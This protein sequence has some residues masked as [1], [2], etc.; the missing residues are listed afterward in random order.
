[1]ITR[2]FFASCALCA[3]AGLTVTAV[4]AQQSTPGIV[5]T[6]LQ[7]SDGPADGYVTILAR[8]DVPPGALVARHT[9]PR[10]ETAIILVGGGTLSVKG[11]PDRQVNSGDS[12]Q[13]PTGVPHALQNGNAPTSIASTYVVEK[14]KPLA[15]PAP[16]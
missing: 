4:E 15:T 13:I 11:Q 9:H 5:R 10:I 7:Q 1:M 12:F 14:G 8:G 6:M 16:E 3:A 2:R